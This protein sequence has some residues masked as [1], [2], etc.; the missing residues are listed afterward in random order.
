MIIFRDIHKKRVP[1]GKLSKIHKMPKIH[2]NDLVS[3]SI[4][5]ELN[6][7]HFTP[8]HQHTFSGEK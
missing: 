7:E 3:S 4:D 1:T 8:A 5:A 6:A 2:L